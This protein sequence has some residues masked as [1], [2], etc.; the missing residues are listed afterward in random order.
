MKNIY[1][2]FIPHNHQRYDTLGDWFYDPQGCI[3]VRVSNDKGHSSEEQFLIAL[4]ELIELK[5]CQARGITQAQVDAFDMNVWPQLIQVGEAN[6]NAEPGD[7]ISAPY[8]RE[9][10]FAMMIEHLVAHELK[11]TGYGTVA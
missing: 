4:H 10:R 7:Y 11:L 1:I 2:Q 9:H 5:L 8:C 3:Q 6:E